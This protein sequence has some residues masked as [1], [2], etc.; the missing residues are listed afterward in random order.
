MI[1]SNIRNEIEEQI[2]KYLD[3][4]LSANE[5]DGLWTELIQDDYYYD[6]LK[7]AAS[8]KGLSEKKRN[9][10]N[11]LN[12]GG[13]KQTYLAAAVV[14]IAATLV[15]FNIGQDVGV[16]SVSP[17]SS[18]ELDYYRSAEGM[19]LENEFNE[20]LISAISAANRGEVNSAISII[21]DRLEQVSDPATRQELLVTA[22]SIFYNSGN[23][24][25]AVVK[26]EEGIAYQSDD[27]LLVERNY[28][29]LGNTYFQLNRIEEAKSA[30]ESAYNMNGAYS[31]I[32]ESYLKALSE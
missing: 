24:S 26:F 30:L 4:E 2:E 25:Q 9:K 3:G 18:I 19:V 32:A 6:Y 28:W 15:L 20:L 16:N 12:M 29:Y 11:I 1:E 7:T 23:Y 31:R 27:V 14:I 8:L 10:N 21:E 13:V 5:I 17:V 22:G